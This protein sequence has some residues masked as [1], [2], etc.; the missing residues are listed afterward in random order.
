MA[1]E[2]STI[3]VQLWYATESVAGVRPVSGYTQLV[4][5]K[6]APS[7]GDAPNTLQVT[8]LDDEYHRY[9]LGVQDVG[10]A[11]AYVF[12]DTVDTRA[13]WG[14]MYEAYQAAA[15]AGKAIWF[16]ERF[17]QGQGN[18]DSFYFA[19]MPSKW[20][21]NERGVDAVIEGTGYITPNE[22]IG[23]AAKSTD[24]VS[25]TVT[26]TLTK[27]STSNPSTVAAGS[28][29]AVLTPD[30]GYTLSSVEVTVGGTDKTSTAYNSA[31]GTIY[32]A[33]VT[34]NIVIEATATT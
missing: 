1:H 9:V 10:G 31:N 4:G 15:A 5:L 17:P 2:L 7:T 16:E 33:S 14:A 25:Y 8:D 3:G 32:I 23:F 24:G 27:C 20:S 6:S 30:D 29:F 22:V 19:G 26:N 12:N 34:G 28:Y 21:V 13:A 11:R 18:L